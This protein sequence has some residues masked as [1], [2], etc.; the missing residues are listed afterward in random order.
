MEKDVVDKLIEF[1]EA[2]EEKMAFLFL[3]RRL[4]KQMEDK[5]KEIAELREEVL[6]CRKKLREEV[7]RELARENINP[8]LKTPILECGLPTYVAKDLYFSKYEFMNLGE[9]LKFTRKELLSIRGFGGKRLDILEGFLS[10]H[11]LKLAK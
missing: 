5:D 7:N 1:A 8:I 10:K 11:G 3:L 2:S 9:V 4:T 6:S